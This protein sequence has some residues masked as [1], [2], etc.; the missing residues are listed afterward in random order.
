M[1]RDATAAS[2]MEEL[3]R[4]MNLKPHWAGRDASAEIVGPAD[5]E[6]HRG[7]DSRYYV[8]DHARLFPPEAPSA[9]KN[10]LFNLLRPEFVKAYKKPLSSDAFSRMTNSAADAEPNN[11][12]VRVATAELVNTAIPEFVEA[13]EKY[14]GADA[15]AG[16]K[17]WIYSE[18]SGKYEKRLPS[19]IIHLL[20]FPTLQ[21]IQKG[22]EDSN[23]GITSIWNKF[24]L[25]LSSPASFSSFAD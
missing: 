12:E 7:L 15:V 10:H 9:S 17:F 24:V 6:V 11:D 18:M 13:F 22:T 4:E 1:K 3:G 8:I 23:R 21:C 19:E 2:L 25:V 5:I 20:P 14:L 16:D